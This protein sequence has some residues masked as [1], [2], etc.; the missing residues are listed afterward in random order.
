MALKQSKQVAAGLP[1]PAAIDAVSLVPILAEYVVP[2]G[3][4]AIGDVVEMG[5]LPAGMV[6]LDM[7]VHN[8]A[9]AASSTLAFGLMSGT[10]GSTDGAR[11]CGAEFIA[12]YSVTAAAITRM[13]KAYTAN[14]QTDDTKGWGF[15]VAGAALQAGQIIRAV[16]FCA[17]A[18]IGIA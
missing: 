18:P 12:A 14:T 10:Y 2:T 17:P 5:G 16:L 13:G 8:S 7:S 9:G 15:V 4:I 6:P 3:G 11:T 1:I